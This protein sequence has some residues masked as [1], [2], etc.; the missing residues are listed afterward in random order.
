MNNIIAIS[1]AHHQAQYDA[2]KIAKEAKA[3]TTV[4]GWIIEDDF[5]VVLNITHISN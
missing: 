1:L 3:A 5:P 4:A 2:T